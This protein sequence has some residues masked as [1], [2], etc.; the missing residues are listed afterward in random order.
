MWGGGGGGDGGMC[1]GEGGGGGSVGEYV[2]FRYKN[3]SIRFQQPQAASWSM[4]SGRFF[5]K[6]FQSSSRAG[7]FEA[8]TRQ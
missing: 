3:R 2:M 7:R 6:S 1:R 8:R 4:K 5:R